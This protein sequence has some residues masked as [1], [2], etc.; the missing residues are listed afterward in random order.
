M[1]TRGYQGKI[2]KRARVYTND[3]GHSLEVLRITAF[4]RAPIHLSAR[5]VYLRG[6]TGQSI[7][8]SIKI[9]AERDK[10]L[11]LKPALF[12]LG[13]KVTYRM[14]EVEM[15]KTFL[16][17]F[18]NIPGPAETYHGFLK[19]KTNYPEKPEISIRIRGKFR[20]PKPPVSS[21]TP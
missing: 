2:N 6:V 15:G 9:S 20:S 16:I 7:T 18:T 8:K 3:P 4:V 11:K 10:P 21:K 1:K 17:H 12:N 19:L 5:Y 13:T 14:E